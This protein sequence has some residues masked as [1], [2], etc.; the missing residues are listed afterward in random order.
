VAFPSCLL[1]HVMRTPHPPDAPPPPPKPTHPH[2]RPPFSALDTVPRVQR[3]LKTTLALHGYQSSND[4]FTLLLSPAH[5]PPP[6][7]NPP[8]PPPPPFSCTQA[9]RGAEGVRATLALHGY[10]SLNAFFTVANA[11]HKAYKEE[12]RMRQLKRERALQDQRRA[13]AATQRQAAAAAAGNAGGWGM[14]RAQQKQQPLI[15]VGIQQP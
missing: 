10:H 5:S 9:T 1:L 15:A 4:S 8:P 11:L 14:S 2:P 6:P 13:R 12:E 7:P 3:R